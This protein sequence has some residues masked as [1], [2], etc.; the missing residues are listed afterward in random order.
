[1]CVIDAHALEHRD[2]FFV[3]REFGDCFL[4]GEMANFINRANHLPVD[5]VMQDLFD[6]T[7]VNFQK[8]DGKMFEIAE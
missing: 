7:A 1:M 8:V 3:F 2:D 4:A 6:K 5:R